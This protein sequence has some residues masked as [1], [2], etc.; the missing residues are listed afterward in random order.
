MLMSLSLSSS[1]SVFLYFSLYVFLWAQAIVL[2]I[3]FSPRGCCFSVN[4]FRLITRSLTHCSSLLSS[5][6]AA[7][8]A[9]PSAS[10]SPPSSYPSVHTALDPCFPFPHHLHITLSG[11]VSL[12][13]SSLGAPGAEGVQLGSGKDQRHLL[14]SQD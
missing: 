4:C 3:F 8:V 9:A 2:S 11:S 12:S 14:K 5:F 10:A 13:V 1:L 7:A 6:P